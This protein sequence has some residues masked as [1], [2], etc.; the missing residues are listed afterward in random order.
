MKIITDLLARINSKFS[1]SDREISSDEEKV[2]NE[3]LILKEYLENSQDGKIIK[4]KDTTN[5]K[6][7]IRCYMYELSNWTGIGNCSH[8]NFYVHNEILTGVEIFFIPPHDNSQILKIYPE[9]ELMS[10]LEFDDIG[11]DAINFTYATYKSDVLLTLTT[12]KK[13]PNRTVMFSIF[14]FDYSIEY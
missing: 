11:F 7:P 9:Y 10:T 2:Y 5:A 3:S 1:S 13:Q 6:G 8:F 4:I 12:E 14:K